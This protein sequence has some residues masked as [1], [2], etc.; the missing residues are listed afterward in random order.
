MNAASFLIEG[1]S[2][3]E[4]GL[5]VTLSETAEELVAVV[6]SHCWSLDGIDGF[7]LADQAGRDPDAEQSILY[8]SEVGLGAVTDASIEP[9]WLPRYLR[10][11]ESG[12][13]TLPRVSWRLRQA[14]I[15]RLP[16]PPA[17]P[18]ARRTRPPCLCA[19][20][21]DRPIR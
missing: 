18:S 13:S 5:Y 7:E 20:L 9:S 6:Q 14:P 21:R 2:R 16:P 19:S 8:P 10:I 17:S 4:R 15:S 1:A 12:S 11:N 3:G